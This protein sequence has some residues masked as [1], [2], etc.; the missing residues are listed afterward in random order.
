MN[1]S[2]P[3]AGSA[4]NE[5]FVVGSIP[6]GELVKYDPQT[7]ELVPYL[8][9]IS[10]EGVEASRDGKWLAYTLFPEGTLW[11][12]N[13]TGTERVQLTFPPMRAFLPRWSPDGKQIAFI[14]APT[15]ERWTTYVIP[16]EGGVARQMIP[17]ND[18][19][20][21]ATWMPDDKSIVFGYWKDAESRG[22]QVLDLVTN[23]VRALPGATEMWSPR[24]S[25]DGRYIAALSQQD[26]K[27]MLFD[28]RTEKWEELAAH[29]SGYPSWSRNGKFLYFQV[30]N[31]GIGYPARV[32]RIRISDR[33][34]E[35]VL[36]FNSLDRLSIGTFMSWS[37]LALD[38]SVL[39]SRNNSTQEIYGVKW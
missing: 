5:A 19:T 29:Y 4:P 22:I 2:Q 8:S 33:R 15:G 27:M 26:S 16:A 24:T 10:A 20:A 6:R 36:D 23:Q 17:G 34:L 7:A 31:R 28:T 38:D 21:D 1:V 13:T 9:G 14:G 39:L 25:P 37:G 18:Q 35:T 12:T 11:R 30:W 3:S 32:V